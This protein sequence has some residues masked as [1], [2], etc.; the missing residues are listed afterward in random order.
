MDGELSNFKRR[1]L[2]LDSAKG[3]VS[4]DRIDNIISITTKLPTDIII[5]IVQAPESDWPTPH[6]EMKGRQHSN[7]STCPLLVPTFG[8]KAKTTVETKT[9]PTIANISVEVDNSKPMMPIKEVESTTFATMEKDAL[10][11]IIQIGTT[12]VPTTTPILVTLDEMLLVRGSKR[13]IEDTAQDTQHSPKTTKN[14][15][16]FVDS[17]TVMLPAAQDPSAQSQAEQRTATLDT[18]ERKRTTEMKAKVMVEKMPTTK[19]ATKKPKATKDTNLF[20]SHAHGSLAYGLFLTATKRNRM[21]HTTDCRQSGVT[22]QI[23]LA[24]RQVSFAN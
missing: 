21:P 16:D 1:V 6:P 3:C 10:K 7:K 13:P 20:W 11:D 9:K 5:R 15:E 2:P 19:S 14:I 18:I 24:S 4:V 17:A 12:E 23:A 22:I 8:N